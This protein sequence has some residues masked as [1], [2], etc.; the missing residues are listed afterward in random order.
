[1]TDNRPI[2]GTSVYLIEGELLYLETVTPCIKLVKPIFKYIRKEFCPI[3][4]TYFIKNEPNI[5]NL[6]N[7]QPIA[8]FI[9]AFACFLLHEDNEGIFCEQK[10]LSVSKN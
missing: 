2:N 5:G 1:M 10:L 8:P 7:F 4:S 6:A 9:L 3:T